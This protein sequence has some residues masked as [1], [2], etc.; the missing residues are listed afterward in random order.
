MAGFCQHCGA[1]HDDEAR[2][3]PKCGQPLATPQPV[4]T[5]AAAP[6]SFTEKYAGTPF[7]AAP[8][9]TAWASPTPASSRRPVVIGVVVALA[10]VALI[11]AW[12]LGLFS[13]FTSSAGTAGN[14]PPTGQIWFGSSFDTT[15]FALSGITTTARTGTTV[16]LV[17][18]LPRSIST[19]AASMRVSLN[20]TLVVNQAVNMNG[21]GDLF[22]TTVG[23]LTISGTYKYE[24]VD[25]GGNLLASGTLTVSQ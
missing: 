15:T 5:P 8:S 23:P 13:R 11:G 25:L 19:G 18:L 24:L 2:F 14:I 9:Q 1:A 22:G 6:T 21:S 17:A 16:A 7:A 3:C 4:A 20:G 12:Q 10:V